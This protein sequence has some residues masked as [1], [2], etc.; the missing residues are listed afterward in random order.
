[1][2]RTGGNPSGNSSRRT[3]LYSLRRCLIA[4]LS[5]GALNDADGI[6]NDRA[7]G[8]DDSD[9]SEDDSAINGNPLDASLSSVT[10]YNMAL[11]P[12]CF[13]SRLA[14]FSVIKLNCKSL[15]YSHIT[16]LGRFGTSISAVNLCWIFL[17]P[18]GVLTSISNVSQSGIGFHW[19]YQ[20]I[21]SIT[22]NS[23]FISRIVACTQPDHSPIVM[24]NSQ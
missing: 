9:V 7:K 4:G 23:A 20:D 19:R 18:S 12:L 10:K 11:A 1:M 21:P 6:L 5:T 3:S 8:E 16:D 15:R 14:S 13:K 22:S 24:R 17:T 2:L